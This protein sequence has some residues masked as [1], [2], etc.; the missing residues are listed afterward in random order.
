MK[1]PIKKQNAQNAHISS[2]DGIYLRGV[3]SNE[4]RTSV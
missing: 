1:I 4:C 2:Y 3:R